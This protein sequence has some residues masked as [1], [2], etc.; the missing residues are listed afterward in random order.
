MCNDSL[1]LTFQV[2]APTFFQK[3][4]D[5]QWY[6]Q[7]LQTLHTQYSTQIS[8]LRTR[9]PGQ[10]HPDL[11]PL[12]N[13]PQPQPMPRLRS[14]RRLQADCETVES[15][16]L[17]STSE[18]DG[19]SSEVEESIGESTASN[20]HALPFTELDGLAEPGFEFKNLMSSSLPA[21]TELFRTA[22]ASGKDTSVSTPAAGVG[23]GSSSNLP[24]SSGRNSALED[25]LM[26]L[27]LLDMHKSS[28]DP[29]AAGQ[30]QQ[31]ENEAGASVSPFHAESPQPSSSHSH[32][33]GGGVGGA[34]APPPRE[35]SPSLAA[36]AAGPSVSSA[37]AAQLVGSFFP[38]DANTDLA[39][40]LCA[41]RGDVRGFE[42]VTRDCTNNMMDGENKIAPRPS[43]AMGDAGHTGRY[44]PRQK[45][46]FER[47][48]YSILM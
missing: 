42:P 47:K 17:S 33:G 35:F 18:S 21:S 39:F 34:S 9:F 32:R 43:I 45:M 28:R 13:Q 41:E 12:P 27:R 37:V 36:A 7:Q 20:D 6:I 16:R 25:E 14:S 15:G 11:N 2:R 22:A 40:A 5:Q 46:R 38:M 31:P 24:Q 10:P 1:T 26:L 8:E 4:R 30:S 48:K 23:T 19:E 44:L 29:A 3:S